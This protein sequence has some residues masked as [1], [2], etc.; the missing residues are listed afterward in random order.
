ME[1]ARGDGSGASL[2]FSWA[3]DRIRRF[4]ELEFLHP[5]T[6]LNMGWLHRWPVTPAVP[7]QITR[8]SPCLDHSS[9]EWLDTSVNR[10]SCGRNGIISCQAH[11]DF[12]SAKTDRSWA[13]T[14]YRQ[15]EKMPLLE[16]AWEGRA[17]LVRSLSGLKGMINRSFTSR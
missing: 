9:S 10:R 5:K 7:P 6:R 13:L 3:L 2:P 15:E 11:A 14:L 4:G 1:P 12:S 17:V 8:C 16:V